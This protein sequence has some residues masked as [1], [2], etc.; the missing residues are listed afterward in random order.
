MTPA[1]VQELA[2][3]YFRDDKS[4]KLLIAPEG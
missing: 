3:K 2:R 1:R 4:W